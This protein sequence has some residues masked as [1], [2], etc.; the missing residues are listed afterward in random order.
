MKRA[1]KVPPT[2]QPV[3]RSNEGGTYAMSKSALADRGGLVCR[4]FNMIIY[5]PPSRKS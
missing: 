5:V 1:E 4:R 3:A 2:H